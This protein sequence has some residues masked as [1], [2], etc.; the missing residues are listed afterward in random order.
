MEKSRTVY[1]KAPGVKAT[2]E[3]V[4][5]DFIEVMTTTKPRRDYASD[6]FMVGATP[7]TI[8]VYPNGYKEEQKGYV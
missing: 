5:Q 3:L 1:A 4:I 8:D 2:A 6:N 7:M